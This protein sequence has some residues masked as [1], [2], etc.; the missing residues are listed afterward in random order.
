MHICTGGGHT[1]A[2]LLQS[3][4]RPQILARDV[5]DGWLPIRHEHLGLRGEF[6]FSTSVLKA[7]FQNSI[8]TQLRQLTLHYYSHE[9]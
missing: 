9:E 7:V 5:Q 3:E 2:P 4:V 1:P 8:S 6:F